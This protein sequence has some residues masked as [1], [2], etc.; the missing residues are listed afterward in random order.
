MIGLNPKQAISDLIADL[1]RSSSLYINN[2]KML[3]GN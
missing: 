2:Q 3:R 1:K